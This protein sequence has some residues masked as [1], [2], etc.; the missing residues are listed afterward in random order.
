MAPPIK[1]RRGVCSY[2]LITMRRSNFLCIKV[3]SFLPVQDEPSLITST[4]TPSL[5]LAKP[6]S[7]FGFKPQTSNF[8]TEEHQDEVGTDLELEEHGVDRGTNA[9]DSGTSFPYS[10]S[11]LTLYSRTYY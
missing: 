4:P 2:D 8:T 10:L 7:I 11:V 3:K 6:G 9:S 5:V 1:Q